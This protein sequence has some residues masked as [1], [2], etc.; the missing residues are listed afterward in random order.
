MRL[1]WPF[2][3]VS[4]PQIRGLNQASR[5]ANDGISLA[6]TAEGALSS[7]SNILQRVR[8][9]SVQSANATNS[10]SDRKAIN[11]EANQLIAELDRI[12]TT[13]Q[14]NGKN[15]LDGTASTSV[16]QVGANANQ[17]IT[18]TTGNFRTNTYGAQ[19]SQSTS[20][21]AALRLQRQ[22]IAGAVVINGQ[23][24]A[25][26]TL[27]ATDTAATAAAA[28]N[29]QSDLTGVSATARNIS[30]LKFTTTTG[31]VALDVK[32]ANTD[33]AVSISFTV[34][35]SDANGL[36]GA[37]NA[38][39]DVSGTTGITAELN[40]AK[41]GIILRSSAGDNIDIENN[42]VTAVATLAAQDNALTT[43]PGFGTAASMAAA[44]GTAVDCRFC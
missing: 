32:G 23:K 10:A 29:G 27:T 34:A 2:P 30:E 22:P 12:A 11:A 7:S 33:T 44:G 40:A 5:N 21:A 17:T 8:E 38:F 42:S 3:S 24:S 4:A 9:L 13:T 20:I 19:I 31:T 39:N 15:L 18:T 14:F 36:A 37:V 43:Q 16:F 6:Q 41:D 35:A 1:A 28:I 26:V 25:T